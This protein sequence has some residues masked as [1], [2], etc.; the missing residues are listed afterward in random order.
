VLREESTPAVNRFTVRDI[1]KLAYLDMQ[2][3]DTERGAALLRLALP[4]VQELPRLGIFGQGV[5]DAQI[6]ALLGRSE[7]AFSALRAA[8]G[9]GYRTSVLADNWLLQ[10][11]PF[12]TSIRD[13]PRFVAIVD[14]LDSL[15]AVMRDRLNE[16]EQSG[17]WR[18]LTDLAG[19]T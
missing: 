2:A 3:G 19:A 12:F 1:V 11:D 17:D 7:D 8:I 16:V 10:D 5:R 6:Y 4:V 13:D 18:A 15:N 9:D 14:E